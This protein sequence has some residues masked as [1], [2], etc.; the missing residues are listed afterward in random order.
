[1][2]KVQGFGRLKMMAVEIT[3]SS[4]MEFIALEIKG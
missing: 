1:M 2:L 4:Q 3:L